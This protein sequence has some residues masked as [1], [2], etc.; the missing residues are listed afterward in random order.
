M[1]AQNQNPAWEIIT[2]NQHLHLS[3]KCRGIIVKQLLLFFRFWY[4]SLI[5][6]THWIAPLV[7]TI[8]MDL[9][10]AQSRGR[11]G[12]GVWVNTLK[13]VSW[14]TLEMQFWLRITKNK[15]GGGGEGFISEN[16]FRKSLQTL[17]KTLYT[18]ICYHN[19][20]LVNKVITWNFHQR[21]NWIRIMGGG[22]GVR[23]KL[24]NLFQ[25]REAQVDFLGKF[26]QNQQK[27][28]FLTLSGNDLSLLKG[29]RESE[30]SKNDQSPPPT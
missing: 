2:C 6:T 20:F 16:C 8:R 24:R 10:L 9:T 14:V 3:S 1:G 29:Y 28:D 12:G 5:K 30:W 21:L 4:F 19:N 17:C 22:G 7:Y 11:G 23:V 18:G 27:S 25:I 13:V 26:G 15:G